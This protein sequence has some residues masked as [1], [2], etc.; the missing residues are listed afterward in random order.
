MKK[1][2]TIVLV[3]LFSSIGFAADTWEIPVGRPYMDGDISEWSASGVSGVQW[4]NIDQNY[5]G[6]S[7]D[8]SD[9]KYAAVWN[10][11][12]NRIYVA[13]SLTDT[14]HTFHDDATNWNEQDDCE[15]Y[16]DAGN[17]NDPL[18]N[19]PTVELYGPAQQ[20]VVGPKP[21]G[22]TWRRIDGQAGAQSDDVGAAV[23][24]SGNLIT[25]EVCIVPY[26][27]Y[28]GFGYTGNPEAIKT[29]VASLELGLDVV[30]GSRHTSDTAFGMLCNNLVGKKFRDAGAFQDQTLTALNTGIVPE[31]ATIAL[32]GLGGLALI[33]RKR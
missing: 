29:L 19:D 30:N 25:Y 27:Y 9:A 31:P 4:H 18:Y 8:V 21:D 2:L 10:P 12:N 28:G 24:V 20:W 17:H 22:G 32:L 6:T 5:D 15:F 13:V 23:K 16:I 14:D 11:D 26:D 7:P 1:L 33:R 3:L